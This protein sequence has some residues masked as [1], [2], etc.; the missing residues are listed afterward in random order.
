MK[1]LTVGADSYL[2]SDASDMMEPMIQST[3]GNPQRTI[4]VIACARPRPPLRFA[5]PNPMNPRMKPTTAI[6]IATTI[7]MIVSES[8]NPVIPRTMDAIAYPL[9]CSI[10]TTG[11][12]GW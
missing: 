6:G 4:P 12:T 9:A 3:K 10:R 7:K 8:A 5:L 1:T 11:G 2:V